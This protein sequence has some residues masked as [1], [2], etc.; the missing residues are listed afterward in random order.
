MR[1][2]I[3]FFLAP[4]FE[5]GKWPV[6]WV[7]LRSL[8]NWVQWAIIWYTLQIIIDRVNEGQYEK[9]IA[10]LALMG[11]V[12]LQWDIFWY[13]FRNIFN[14]LS[15]D[16]KKVFYMKY[17]YQYFTSE[18]N[19]IE[20]IGTG[21]IQSIIFQW[22]GAW[23]KT[24]EFVLQTW[25]KLL[26]WIIVGSF[27]IAKNIGIYAFMWVFTLFIASYFYIQYANKILATLRKERRDSMIE[28]DK[29]FVRMIMSKNEILM[30]GKGEHETH[31]IDRY[32]SKIY[33][34]R[35]RES[36]KMIRTFDMQKIVFSIIRIMVI[37][38]AVYLI[39]QGSITIWALWLLWMMV[40][41][42]YNSIMD[43]NEAITNFH[44]DK[45]HIDKLREFTHETPQ[46]KWYQQWSTFSPKIWEIQLNNITYD[47]GK[48]EVINWLS[49]SIEWWQKTAI[50]GR[51]GSGKSTIIKLIAGYIYPQTGSVVIDGQELPNPTND[52]YVSLQSYYKHI[53]YLTQEP[54][55]F[56]GS[57]YEN[58][59]YALEYIPTDEELEKAVNAAQCQFIREFPQG[60]KTE[61]G[62]KWIKL[63]WWQRQRLAIAK[64]F[65]K[66]PAIILLD[67]P[68]SALDSF[69]ED[70]VTKALNLLF[71]SRT[72]IIIAHR[73]Q[74]VK[75]AD[76]IIVLEKWKLVEDGTHQS[77]LQSHWTYAKM[78]ELQSG[79]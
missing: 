55:I 22:C 32:Y 48:W 16:L 1:Q 26:V 72:V 58:L 11:I 46:I 15:F 37:G 49:L 70:E 33:S 4:A 73:L 6:L 21:K 2:K 38:Y 54:G 42:V 52:S 35:K 53:S 9:I 28:G 57:I 61:I 59:T 68:T 27:I 31:F 24:I 66:N 76:R 75:S 36:K 20:W 40:N 51:S 10:P 67:E 63:S 3:C 77:L 56:D 29:R 14:K 62:E 12:L 71:Q 39:K 44:V 74:T 64:V 60:L 5:R 23:Q 69:S 7:I 30:N 19:T 8:F 25:V 43:L 41:Q 18:G 13:F 34:M 65:L 79:F 45:I 78:L 17:M 47:Y 50:I